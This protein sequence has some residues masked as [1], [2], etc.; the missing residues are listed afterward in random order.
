MTIRILLV[1]DD[2]HIC[3]TVKA[4]LTEAGFQVDACMV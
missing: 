1:E 3:N 2:E 4:F